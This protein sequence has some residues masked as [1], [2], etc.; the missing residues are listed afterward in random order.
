MSSVGYQFLCDRLDLSALK[1]ERPARIAP[2]SR[3]TR[4][5]D[6]LLVPAHVA[7]R[8]DAL[9]DHMLFALKHEGIN[10]QVL[11]Q[12][13]SHVSEAMLLEQVQSSPSSRYV[14][15]LGFLWE[16]L[17]GRELT[18]GLVI[19]GP[20][21]DVFDKKR[22]ITAPGQRNARWRVNFNGLGSIR[23]CVTVE[24]S[25]A[26]VRL[27]ERDILG[28]A[29]E[30]LGQLGQHATDRALS[31]AYLHETESSFAIERESPT[32]DKAETF[33][34]LLKQAQQ[35]RRMDEDYLVELQN[36]AI[37]NPFDLAVSFRNEQNW[38]RGP[39]RGA[40]GITYVPP[41]PD[42]ARELME[43][44]LAFVNELPRIIDPLVAAAIGSFGFIF[45][46]P[47]MD[48]NG[49]LSRFLFH[50]ALCQSGSLAHGLVLPVSVAMKRNEEGYLR[51]LQSYSAPMRRRWD[52]RWV[53]G[54]SYDL[55][56]QGDDVLYR[57]WNATPAVEFSLQ[58]ADQALEHDLREET[59]FLDRF[60]RAYRLINERFDVR[61]NDL[62][63]LV[64][65]CLQNNCAV[66]NNR[67]RQFQYRVPEVV[68]D[69]IEEACRQVVQC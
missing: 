59:A 35:P 34:S 52:V 9:I 24:R 63:T 12:T 4:M 11:A 57:Y 43:E 27:L 20:T 18:Q 15:V 6:A 68:F 17:L 21:V 55:V 37:T 28:R 19:A 40:A 8:N 39:L 16:S 62:T 56:F 31:W 26:I 69:A 1:P 10:L 44:V 2:V 30:F 5:N 65:S 29:D 36:A 14:R 49:R 64:V 32:Q 48:G 53:D 13:L 42:L 51:A 60:D 7:P 22:Y 25:E 61:G 46:H 67:R 41:P 47:F 58:M 45:I 66:S 23:Y 33:V 3:L 54:E 38:L 50:Y